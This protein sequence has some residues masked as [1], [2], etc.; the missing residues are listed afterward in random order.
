MRRVERD[1]ARESI[2]R[3][4]FGVTSTSVTSDVLIAAFSFV[5]LVGAKLI[6]N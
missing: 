4:P 2:S 6:S 5:N 1:D 3:L